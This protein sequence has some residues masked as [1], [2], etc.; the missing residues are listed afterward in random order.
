MIQ[1]AE[2]QEQGG[3]LTRD[4]R[5][6]SSKLSTCQREIR[7]NRVTAQQVEELPTD[8]TTYR[9]VGKAFMLTPRTE[10]DKRL[11]SELDTLTKNQADLTDRKVYLERRL[12]SNNQQMKDIVGAA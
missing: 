9:T 11:A 2:C 7:A 5:Q 3:K 10:I 1:L 4:L 8:V 12:E 6:V